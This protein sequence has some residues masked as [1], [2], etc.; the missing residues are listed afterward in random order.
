MM[1]RA[2]HLWQRTRWP[3][4]NV[5]LHYAQTLFNL[6]VVRYLELLSMRVWDAGPGEASARLFAVQQLLDQ[7][8][9]SSPAGQPVIVRDAR[10]L[11]PLAQSPTNEEL[12]PYFEV[13]EH[14]AGSFSAEERLGLY[15]ASVVT[16][17]GH[18]RSQLRH[19]TIK[20]GVD[21][22]E[23]GLVLTSRSTNALDF[24]LLIQGLVPLL[25]A[26]ER[27]CTNGDADRRR[28]LAGTILQGLS[29]D[30]DLFVNRLELLGA[31]S[32]VEHLFVTPGPGNRMIL[33]PMGQR[34][35]QLLEDYQRL[36]VRSAT[37][38]LEDCPAFQPREGRYSPYGLVYG[39]SSNLTEHMAFKALQPDSVTRFSL[40]DVFV[41][42]AADAEKL[43]WVSGWR[44]LPHIEP[45]IQQLFDY[46]Q[47]FAEAIFARIE[48]ALRRR[49][50]VS[51]SGAAVSNGRLHLSPAQVPDLSASVCGILGP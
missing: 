40:E 32:E 22:E 50:V 17:G 47:A 16:A 2:F 44:K 28:P 41:A 39:F 14:I 9:T 43:E 20:N 18:L 11:I 45:A 24:A 37:A 12:G 15:E 7:L 34:H 4:R 21:L 23:N 25:A 10:W 36:I 6:Y 46:P 51:E 3:G 31:Y 35:A 30:P 1:I 5:R 29:V 8:W 13:A 19:Y 42:G 33:T 38:L 49:V 27:A 26:Y 48:R